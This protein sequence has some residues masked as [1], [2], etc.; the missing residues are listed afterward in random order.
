MEK[1]IMRERKWKL[2]TIESTKVW[3]FPKIGK[4]WFLDIS[5]SNNVYLV[6]GDPS[7]LQ[8]FLLSSET[9]ELN[10]PESWREVIEAVKGIVAEK[11]LSQC[12][13]LQWWSLW[14]IP[15]RQRTLP[16][17]GKKLTNII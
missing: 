7:E 4:I 13:S 3:N 2:N 8:D 1:D 12:S 15:V 14:V 5:I 17:K 16:L 6:D 9:L 11:E 10:Y